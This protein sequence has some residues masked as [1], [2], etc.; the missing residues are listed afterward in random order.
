V[1]FEVSK[2]DADELVATLDAA[3]LPG[4]GDDD[5]RIRRVL[6]GAASGVAGALIESLSRTPE[7]PSITSRCSR[8][9][10]CGRRRWRRPASCWKERG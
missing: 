8:C 1:R 6:L 7:P 5:E 4:E 2:K 3:E 10:S 9:G